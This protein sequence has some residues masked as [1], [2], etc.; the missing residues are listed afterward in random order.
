MHAT[1]PA[2]LPHPLNSQQ[3]APCHHASE[4]PSLPLVSPH[5]QGLWDGCGYVAPRFRTWAIR[6]SGQD[7]EISDP[8]PLT[9]PITF[10]GEGCKG[11]LARLGKL[12]M[13]VG[14]DS[15][16]AAQLSGKGSQAW[17]TSCAHNRSGPGSPNN[18]GG[19]QS[20]C[21]ALGRGW[22]QVGVPCECLGLRFWGWG[23]KVTSWNHQQPCGW[24][25][26]PKIQT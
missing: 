5:P 15:P 20:T 23:K 18:S 21:L 1:W 24:G 13:V 22:M 12:D 6:K 8:L 10:C 9:P 26:T 17:S 7:Q 14:N 4:I 2:Q 19:A 3:Q 25:P 11:P 16:N